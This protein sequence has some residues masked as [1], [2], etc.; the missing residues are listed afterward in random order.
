M[1]Y[2]K[3]LPAVAPQSFIANGT[4]DGKV[5]VADASL[6]KVKQNV[7]ILSSTQINPLNVQVKRIDD[8]NT[9][10]VGDPA[11][12]I[13]DRT[14]LTLY[15]VADSANISAIEQNRPSIPEEQVERLT[16]EEEP[17]IARRAVLV[18]KMGNKIDNIKDSNGVNRLAVDGQ[19]TAEVDVQVD[20]DIDGY[21]DSLTNPDP[22][23][24]GLIGHERGLTIDQTSQNQRITAKRGTVDLDTISQDVS[25]H[26]NDGNAYTQSNPV[27]V[28]SQFEKFFPL[29]AASK[30]MELGV[31]DEIVPTYSNSNTTLTLAY[32][33]DGALLGEAV[34]NLS[35][36]LVWDMVLNRYINDDDGTQL[37]DDD[38]SAL[39]LD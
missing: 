25:L 3:R 27:P 20:V 14:D 8:I 15:L 38:G 19:F 7:V 30:W 18:D 23:N 28:T 29:I 33:E 10:Y 35:S 34:L 13:T 39:N 17:T 6:F 12:A 9:I 22:D 16:Y 5:T 4:Q 1:A 24:I 36:A 2:E 26:D 37:L 21:Y 11:K 31:Y 32:R